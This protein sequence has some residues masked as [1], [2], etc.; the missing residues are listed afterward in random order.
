[1]FLKNFKKIFGAGLAMALALTAAACANEQET[2]N[3]GALGEDYAVLA[4][5]P[6]PENSIPMESG[7]IAE[8]N[9]CGNED[10]DEESEFDVSDG[11]FIDRDNWE[12]INDPNSALTEGFFFVHNGVTIY[13]GEYT[14]RVL[15]ELD[16]SPE[17]YEM[18]SCSFDGIAR[19]YFYDSFDI[20]TYLKT[21]NG[22]DRVY[23]IALSDSSISTYEG[24]AIEQ[25]YED[26]IAA[27]G[28]DYE[29]VEDIPGFYRYIRD[30]T[31]L[32]FNIREEFIASITYTVVDITC[33][34]EIAR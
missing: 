6:V 23:S 33:I 31:A 27:Y 21:R 13:L 8:A 20:E 15:S 9:P 3:G 11:G 1:M 16:S 32:F 29:A 22:R 4:V 18:E 26:M 30:N 7:I 5:E 17:I 2:G 10:C 19:M 34:P 28:E 25:T 12:D 24:V 14:E